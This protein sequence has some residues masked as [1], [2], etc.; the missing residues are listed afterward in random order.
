MEKPALNF[1]FLFQGNL[2]YFDTLAY[3][4]WESCQPW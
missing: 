4:L 3:T 2:V 1:K